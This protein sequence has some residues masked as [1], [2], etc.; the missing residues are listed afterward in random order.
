MQFTTSFDRSLRC[1]FV[2]E[3]VTEDW[4]TK[5]GVYENSIE[6]CRPNYRFGANTSCISITKI[7]SVT[8]ALPKWWEFIS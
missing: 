6:S 5:K 1:D 3:N 4:E 8:N 2:V 7:G